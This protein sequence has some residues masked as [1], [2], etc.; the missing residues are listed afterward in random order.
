MAVS[1]AIELPARATVEHL[2]A[3]CAGEVTGGVASLWSLRLREDSEPVELRGLRWSG[4]L[5]SPVTLRAA[6]APRGR[7]L[8]VSGSVRVVPVME[9]VEAGIGVATLALA[10][11]LALVGAWGVA[12]G[13]AAISLVF[14]LLFGRSRA[15]IDGDE[16]E[17][18]RELR[19]HLVTVV[20]A[21]VGR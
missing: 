3:G 18:A 8:V 9:R 7:R 16:H 15:R 5:I 2:R 6:V 1:V 21:A 10:G 14:G 17:A 13:T 20:S 11:V 12:A 19:A 4:Q